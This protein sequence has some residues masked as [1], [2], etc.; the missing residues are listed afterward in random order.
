MGPLVS[1]RD[2]AALRPVSLLVR[3]LLV[4]STAFSDDLRK[5]RG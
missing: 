3:P 2:G 1:A 5:N 4:M